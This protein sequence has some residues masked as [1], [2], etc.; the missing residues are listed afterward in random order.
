MEEGLEDGQGTIQKPTSLPRSQPCPVGSRGPS[1][2][3]EVKFAWICH[4]S[5]FSHCPPE[6]LPN[7]TWGDTNLVM[8]LKLLGIR[9]KSLPGKNYLS[10][11]AQPLCLCVLGGTGKATFSR[12]FPQV[13]WEEARPSSVKIQSLQNKGRTGS[14]SEK[15]GRRVF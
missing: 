3:W 7:V 9:G 10:S 15:A 4:R 11:L 13:N 1:V 2:V 8:G 6:S 5:F 12:R 14:F